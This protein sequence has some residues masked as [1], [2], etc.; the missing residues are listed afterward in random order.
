M[1]GNW[2][3]MQ[4]QVAGLGLKPGYPREWRNIFRRIAKFDICNPILTEMLIVCFATH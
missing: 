1:G 2:P 3:Y 4:E